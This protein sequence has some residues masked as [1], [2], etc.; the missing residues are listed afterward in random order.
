M[1]RCWILLSI[2]VGCVLLVK[3]LGWLEKRE[4]DLDMDYYNP[5]WWT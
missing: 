1:T 2:V 5:G 4:L 3:W